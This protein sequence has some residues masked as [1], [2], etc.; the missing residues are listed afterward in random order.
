MMLTAQVVVTGS[1]ARLAD[2]IMG[3]A[4][5]AAVRFCR[6]SGLRLPGHGPAR[7]RRS[8]QGH[9]RRRRDRGAGRDAG[10]VG[11]ADR[12]TPPSRTWSRGNDRVVD[13]ARVGAIALAERVQAAAAATQ[14]GVDGA[15]RPLPGGRPAAGRR[16][17]PDPARPDGGRPRDRRPARP[18]L[19]GVA[20]R[21]LAAAGGG[22]G[23][24]RRAAR[25]RRVCCA[26]GG[27]AATSPGLVVCEI[28]RLD[29][30]PRRTVDGRFAGQLA[31]L[32]AAEGGDAR[33]RSTPTGP[34]RTAT[35]TRPHRPEGPAGRGCGRP[36]TPWPC[37]PG[38]CRVEQ[39][40]ACWAALRG[41]RRHGSRTP[42]DPRTRDQI[43]ADALVER[44]TGQTA[45]QRRAGRGG[46]SCSR[47]DALTDPSGVGRRG[48]G[49]ARPD[50]R[51]AG[52][53]HPGP[54]AGAGGGGGGCSPPRTA[55]SSAATPGGGA[56]TAPSPG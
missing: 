36:R 30:D 54:I 51:R 28:R 38:S 27:S 49:R 8:R 12:G 11:R 48:G 40:V 17:R 1:W 29:P 31:G 53:G 56:S 26:T 7:C 9:R 42:A 46:P 3:F 32:C 6:W 16:G 47:V 55:G 43:M 52:V 24:A 21:G 13:A 2:V 10:P 39:G 22:P 4:C 35:R 34:T 19:P 15:V 41:A 25:H 14:G 50:A 5:S 20:D 33:P 45:R 23:A 18:G 37:C 44:L